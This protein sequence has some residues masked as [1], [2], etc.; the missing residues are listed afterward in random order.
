MWPP[1]YGPVYIGLGRAFDVTVAHM[2]EQ[3]SESVPI[4]GQNRI[5]WKS[6]LRRWPDKLSR[7]MYAD[8]IAKR[9]GEECEIKLLFNLRFILFNWDGG[10]NTCWLNGGRR[11]EDK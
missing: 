8:R 4:R 3:T 2:L 9:E 11:G 6:K 7:S 1:T 5:S 10:E